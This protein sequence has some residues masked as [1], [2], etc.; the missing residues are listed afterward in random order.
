MSRPGTEALWLLSI[1]LLPILAVAT[2]GLVLLAAF[3][4]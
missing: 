2:A 4:R 1:A 3:V